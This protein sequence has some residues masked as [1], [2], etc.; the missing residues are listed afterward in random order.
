VQPVDRH[1]VNAGF[2]ISVISASFTLASSAAAIS[3]GIA[4]STVVLLAFGAVGLLDAVGS[5]A[6]AYHFKH[7]LRHDA[8]SDELERLAHRIV[9]T[10]LLVVGLSAV[11]VGATRLALGASSDTTI[12]GIVL[13][14]VS[15]A[16]LSVLAWRKTVI[17]RRVGS[18]ALRSDG[19]LSAIGA[20]QAGV[21]LAG[22]AA[23]YWF[24]W[25]SADAIAT[26]VV[27]VLAI[28][29]SAASWYS[30]SR[31]GGVSPQ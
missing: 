24:D 20:A 9:L 7:G 23:T 31:S 26:T 10:G 28:T 15:L 1:H 2:R 11:I 14:S 3:V 4:T 12:A 21:A 6:L 5:I 22:T 25:S 8:L 13:A 30:H 17:A 19:H 18:A 27:G 29:V 16:V